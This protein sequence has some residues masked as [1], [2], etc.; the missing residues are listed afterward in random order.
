MNTKTLKL[1]ATSTVAIA[2]TGCDAVKDAIDEAGVTVN[3]VGT[4]SVDGDE[5]DTRSVVLYTPTDNPDAFD[6]SQC[7]V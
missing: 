4:L 1:V 7:T 5:P 3:V 2:L 6:D